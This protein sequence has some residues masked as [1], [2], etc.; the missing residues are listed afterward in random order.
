VF[1]AVVGMMMTGDYVLFGVAIAIAA[2]ALIRLA[3]H[4]PS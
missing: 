1:G 3:G 4:G 2:V